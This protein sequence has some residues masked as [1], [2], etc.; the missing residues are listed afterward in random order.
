MT[1][2]TLTGIQPQPLASYLR[3]L[4]VL[5]L[6]ADQADPQVRGAWRRGS[7]VLY[8]SLNEGDLL[9]FFCRRYVPTPLL[10]PWNGG[11]GFYDG[12]TRSGYDAIR[13]SEDPRFQPYRSLIRHIETW[14]EMPRSFKTVGQVLRYLQAQI[15]SS[16]PSK[17][18][19]KLLDRVESIRSTMEAARGVP[20]VSA[21]P[22]M[23]IA[24]MDHLRR[25]LARGPMRDTITAWYQA[26]RKGRSECNRLA[27]AGEAKA[28]ILAACRARMPDDALAWVDTVVALTADGDTAYNPL[29]GNGGNEGRLDFSNNFMQRL[30]ELLLQGSRD[31]ASLLGSSLFGRL[32]TGMERAPFGQFDPGRAGGPNQGPGIEHGAAINPWDF[33]LSLEGTL[34]LA[35]S[36]SRRAAQG[37]RGMA[38]LPFTVRFRGVGFTSAETS[39]KGKAEIWLPLWSWPAGQA[40]IRHL[41]GEGRASVGRRIARD[42]LDFVRALSTLGVD[43]GLDSFV[44]YT[45]LERR[46]TNYVAL[47]AGHHQVRHRPRARL[48]DEL[49][50]ALGQLDR[51]LS[52]FPTV[53]ASLARARRQMDEAIYRVAIRPEPARFRKLLRC[54]GRLEQ[55]LARRDP[56]REP[57]LS[58]PLGGLSAEWILACDPGNLQ[59]RLAASLASL[60][61]GA[62]GAVGPIRS[63]LSGVDPAK[64]WSYGSGHA[65]R[66]WFG[67]NLPECLSS[68]LVRRMMDASRSSAQCAPLGGFWPVSPADVAEFLHAG[69]GDDR[70]RDLLWG[71]TWIRHWP[72]DP[73]QL[74]SIRPQ[75]PRLPVPREWAL[76]RL[77]LWH[78]Q[79]PDL[80]LR[81]EPRIADLLRAG[82]VDRAC[83]LALLRL[84]VAGA[85]PRMVTYRS[86]LPHHRLAAS[87]LF[88]LSSSLSLQRLVLQPPNN[89]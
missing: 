25:Q 3:A 58:S 86:Q 8:S 35:S 70:I 84:R 24:T 37:A 36:V 64:P 9:D 53:P 45:I 48:L 7:F 68:V 1:E 10:S 61:G 85:N 31:T 6:V 47:P 76:L 51:L 40:E 52:R 42:G 72:R 38:A 18:R 77:A 49:D 34:M 67:N 66:A 23:G 89:D 82:H 54:I 75:G 41:F 13:D 59:V 81:L 15:D 69:T 87:L 46:G 12:D 27:R 55:A 17:K 65:Q 57:S 14:P 74:P 73:G 29:L 78:R 26:A 28:A 33:V 56:Q 44:R 39:E 79:L 19:D 22:E 11:S 30:A 71:F 16:R 60:R 5:R 43:R 50:P 32:S 21:G 2:T 4:A 62:A 88:P 80:H 63:N 20:G 83:A